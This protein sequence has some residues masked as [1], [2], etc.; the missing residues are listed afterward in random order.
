MKKSE[1]IFKLEA[2]QKDHSGHF[3]WVFVSP[4]WLITELQGHMP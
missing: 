2:E 3:D 4:L 1:L